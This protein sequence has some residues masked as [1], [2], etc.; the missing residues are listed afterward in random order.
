MDFVTGLL[1]S[2]AKNGVYNLILVIVDRYT[3]II[4]YL[5]TNITIDAAILADLFFEEVILRYGTPARIITNRGSVF[6][7]K[8]WGAIYYYIKIKRYLSIAFYP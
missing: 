4:R 7:S 8:F 1:A 5:P 6:T 2:K 3:K